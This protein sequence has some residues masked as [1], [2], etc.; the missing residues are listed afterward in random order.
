MPGR[1]TWVA[2]SNVAR[3]VVRDDGT[4]WSWGNAA[5]GYAGYIVASS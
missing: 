2:S 3:F 4:L 1:I 5:G